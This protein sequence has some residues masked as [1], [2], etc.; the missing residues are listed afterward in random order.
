[1]ESA[2]HKHSPHVRKGARSCVECRQRKI[3]C[4]WPSEDAEV[5][6]NCLERRR[7]C[8]PQKPATQ[9]P[10]AGRITS[11]GRITKL[12]SSISQLW[13]LVRRLEG[14]VPVQSGN[15]SPILHRA[16]NDFNNAAAHDDAASESDSS[17]LSPANPP[18]HLRQ[19]FEDGPLD[20]AEPESLE[21][22][23][24]QVSSTRVQRAR[25]SLGRLMPS[26]EDAATVAMQATPW[27]V[28]TR[29]LFIMPRSVMTEAQMLPLWDKS[30]QPDANPT[31]MAN[32]LISFVM[33]IHQIPPAQLSRLLSS[34]QGGA[35]YIR[36]VSDAVE[37][38][39]V[40]DDVLAASVDGLGAS[41]FW[42]R[43]QLVGTRTQKVWI[44]LRRIITLAELIGLPRAMHQLKAF[45]T[46]P[47]TNVS[48]SQRERTKE[49]AEL[50][51]S[52]CAVDRLAAMMFNLP[53]G[54]GSHVYVLQEPVVD[55][56]LDTQLYLTRL[57]DVACGVQNVDYLHATGTPSSELCENVLRLDQQLR[58]L[59][60]LAPE[61][62]WELSSEKVSAVHILQ[63]FH[64]YI[65]IRTHVQ[66]A[67]KNQGND[68]YAYSD[69]VCTETCRDLARRYHVLRG[70]LPNGF[71][72]CRLLDLQALTAAIFL[73]I[74]QHGSAQQIIVSTSTHV[75]A[76]ATTRLLLERLLEAM[77]IGAGK[78]GGH[79][80]RQAA[81]AIR[82]VSDLLRNQEP[83]GNQ[84]LTLS[85]PLL[86]R[87]DVRRK[88]PQHAQRQAQQAQPDRLCA[89]HSRLHNGEPF[90]SL[91][92]GVDRQNA[93]PWSVEISSVPA[94]LAGDEGLSLD[95]W[96]SPGAADL[97]D[98][99]SEWY[100]NVYV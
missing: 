49:A 85:V 5:C 32:L 45:D 48:R 28:L 40:K 76:D 71:F 91:Q 93:A 52:I 35:S 21:L 51:V 77:E 74:K 41:L 31:D 29:S 68:L 24:Q 81:K 69:L 37:V 79:F 8:I 88:V 95:Q 36:Q 89:E 26:R 12:E 67:L 100:P 86:G 98:S 78:P 16:S 65:T 22:S 38:A 64:Q 15:A 54:T 80:A 6:G 72:A 18:T 96:L 13:T 17:D 4:L 57:A 61:G 92:Q 53:L 30:Q 11:R 25:S 50:W 70:L 43:L 47:E 75:H 33:T 55:G 83:S 82:S 10:L 94:F 9:D 56:Q 66:L 59:A 58:A 84:S 27:L 97:G 62:W 34:V 23:R 39:I 20:F 1:M 19:L 90:E 87:I 7:T 46:Q 60:C 42:L 3:K 2:A 73:L 14:A 44:S 63:Y 99:M